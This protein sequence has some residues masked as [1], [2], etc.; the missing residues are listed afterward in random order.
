MEGPTYHASVPWLAQEP[1][2]SGASYITALHPGGASGNLF[3]SYRPL[4]ALYADFVGLR[5]EGRN[6]F[7][8]FLTSGVK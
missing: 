5:H 3:Q 1:R 2:D 6:M 4:I 7:R 8:V